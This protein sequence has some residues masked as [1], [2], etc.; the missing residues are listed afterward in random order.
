MNG[1]RPAGVP[2]EG[3][4]PRR[5]VDPR[6][7]CPGGLHRGLDLRPASFC[8][9]VRADPHL[10]AGLTLGPDRLRQLAGQGRAMSD[11]G[12]PG[13][14]RLSPAISP[15]RIPKDP[16]SQV[17]SRELDLRGEVKSAAVPKE[18]WRH[19]AGGAIGLHETLEE[20]CRNWVTSSSVVACRHCGSPYPPTTSWRPPRRPPTWP[21]TAA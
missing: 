8:G 2:S 19:L 13:S 9:V 10:R 17:R 18:A 1:G 4:R 5:P 14:G 16:T 11:R 20:S 6:A 21:D 12:R 3:R 15:G 7:R